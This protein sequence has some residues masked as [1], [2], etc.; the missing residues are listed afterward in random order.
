MGKSI[1]V[2]V[3]TVFLS[4]FSQAAPVQKTKVV[5]GIVIDQMR[6]DYLTNFNHVF[7]NNGFNLLKNKGAWFTNCYINYLPAYT[8][9]GHASIYTG[10]V[11]GINGI[12][13]NNW[14]DASLAKNV[15]CVQDTTESA[16]GGSLNLGK[17]SPRNLKVTTVTDEL[18]LSNNF[19]SRTFSVSLK[20]R[21]A[22][23]PGGHSANA[24]YWMEDENGH[25]MT[26][27]YYAQN[28]PS[29]VNLF[30]RQEKA[31]EYLN[32]TWNPLYGE[33][34][35]LY[36]E[37]DENEFEG[38]FGDAQNTSFP[39]NFKNQKGGYIKRTPY[40][41]SILFDFAKEAILNENIGKRGATD[42]LAL[43]FSATDYV[44][45][46]FGPNSWEVEDTYARLDQD[47]ARF[48]RFLNQQYGKEGYL[49]FLTADHG[50][51]HNPNYLKSKKMP[52]AYFFDQKEQLALNEALEKQFGKKDLCI[53]LMNCQVYLNH[54][55]I[56]D[57][58]EKNNIENSIIEY[59]KKH[60][61]VQ[62][63]FQSDRIANV[64]LPNFLKQYY[65]NSFFPSRSGDLSL[66]FY[67][68]VLDAYSTTGTS[69]GAWSAYDSH[70]PLL[71]YGAGLAPK[72]SSQKVYMTDIAP[73]LCNLLGIAAP[74]GSVGN[75]IIHE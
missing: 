24:A 68:G 61:L 15:Y 12:V 27:T 25:F 5:I 44:G 26:S 35:Y 56:E 71:F 3:F 8:G 51:A 20:D 69:H 55:I 75:V 30:N 48:I 37:S 18:R 64:P 11:P 72:K 40:G 70:I 1:C 32:Q 73:T 67:P 36:T 13:G 45:H 14:Y 33:S 47:L 29:W 7:G 53:R 19:S 62:I 58:T 38:R 66:L 41:N 10:S 21:G 39:H 34:K 49:L 31:R 2:L 28:L 60:E 42:F 4:F 65:Q 23:L 6:A 17:I 54:T 52:A 22:V 59:F 43:S 50:A 46:I 57:G 9:P 16:I 63:A 74:N